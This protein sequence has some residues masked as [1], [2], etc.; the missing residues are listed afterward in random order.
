MNTPAAPCVILGSR[1]PRRRELLGRICPPESIAVIAP[2]VESEAG[3]AGLHALPDIEHRLLEIARAKADDVVAQAA[4]RASG[5]RATPWAALIAADTEVVVRDSS[6]KCHALGQPP[7]DDWAEVVR[8]WFRDEYA[9]RTHLAISALVIAA[10]DGRRFER[11]VAT[12]VTFVRDI[13]PWLDWY[14]STGEPQGKA[15][16]YAVQ[17]AGS[18][19][20]ERIEGSLTNVIGLPLEAML[21]G[22]EELDIA[23]V[24]HRA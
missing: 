15:G 23:G 18:I 7:R 14:L 11:L 17:G 4:E 9:G 12:Q 3:F 20:I 10:P 16:G 19:F 21:D 24:A 22:F 5:G 2:R 1:S 8:R 13:E 6:G